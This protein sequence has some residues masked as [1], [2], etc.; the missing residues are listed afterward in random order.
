MNITTLVNDKSIEATTKIT[1]EAT[2]NDCKSKFTIVKLPV[3]KVN[4][5]FT[6]VFSE[7]NHDKYS[8]NID[9]LYNQKIN[10]MREALDVIQDGSK[11]SNFIRQY[12]QD[13][14]QIHE[15][16]KPFIEITSIVCMDYNKNPIVVA[17]LAATLNNNDMQNIIQSFQRQFNYAKLYFDNPYVLQFIEKNY[18]KPKDIIKLAKAIGFYSVLDN[19]TDKA[20]VFCQQ[21]S[22]FVITKRCLVS[23]PDIIKIIANLDNN[24]DIKL[25]LTE[26]ASIK[27]TECQDQLDN[28]KKDTNDLNNDYFKYL[29]KQQDIS[30][31]QQIQEIIQPLDAIKDSCSCSAFMGRYKKDLQ[32]VNELLKPFVTTALDSYKKNKKKSIIIA[33]VA[34]DLKDSNIQH[35]IGSFQSQVNYIESCFNNPQSIEIIEEKY[36]LGDIITLVQAIGFYAVLYDKVDQALVFCKQLSQFVREK[37]ELSSIPDITNTICDI[38]KNFYSA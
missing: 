21:L 6:E 30:K 32:Q 25:A 27:L 31:P 23:I 24:K 16:L 28:N 10:P 11:Y 14:K 19:N 1:K 36:H 7:Q 34:I 9:L 18:A 3:N 8:W 4:S 12:T 5:R 29:D 35:I 38:N 17:K 15:T 37:R 33:K 26:D 22:R 20:L 2:Q 13:F